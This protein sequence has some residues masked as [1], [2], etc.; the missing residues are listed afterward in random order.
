MGLEFQLKEHLGLF[1]T[2]L[3]GMIKIAEY[4]QRRANAVR[5]ESTIR[6]NTRIVIHSARIS[7]IYSMTRYRK[8][9][10]PKIRKTCT[11]YNFNFLVSPSSSCR[12]LYERYDALEMSAYAMNITYYIKSHCAHF[13][14]LLV[15]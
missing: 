2:G 8:K 13:G 5:H 9:S 3:G 14:L 6:R 10:T 12:S 15:G 4:V 1:V 11:A 7:K